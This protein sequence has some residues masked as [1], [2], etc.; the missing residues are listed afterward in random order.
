MKESL[1]TD[2]FGQAILFLVL[3]ALIIPFLR[4]VKIPIALGYLL[5]GIALG[6]YGIGTI[7]NSIPALTH[8][9]LQDTAHV[10]MLAE[11]G[12]ILLLFIIGLEITPRRLWQMR[13]LVFGLGGLQVLIT[14]TIIGTI[15]F[16]WG[17]NAQVSILL[18]LSLA[19]S[20]TAIVIQ[21]LHEQ[22]LFVSPMGRTT[23]SILLL[24]DLAVIPILF[25]LT[26]FTADSGE[27]IGAFLSISLAKM[28]VTVLAMYFLGKKILKPIFIF[29]NRHGGAE[30]FMALS[31]LVIITTASIAHLAGLSMA[32]GAFIAGLLLSDTEYRHEIS[33]LIV[34]FKSM[35]LG[36][37]FI[38]FG[39][40]INLQF[41]AEKPIWLIISVIGLMSIKGVITYIL[42]R[43]WK[44]SNAISLESAILLSQA[45]EF[46]L[47]VTGSALTVGFMEQD[48]GQ[49]MLLTIGIT[50]IA[51]P[52]IAPLARKI[53]AHMETKNSENNENLKASNEEKKQHVVIF[54]FGHVGQTVA[55]I[56]THEGLEIHGFDNNIDHV[57]QAR[58][59]FVPVYY[60]DASRKS[61]IEAAQLDQALCAVITTDNPQT[62]S[63]IVRLIRA[64]YS[65]V[66]LIVRSYDQDITDKLNEYEYV[67]VIP[68]HIL[69]SLKLT[70]KILQSTGY[71][72]EETLRALQS[73]HEHMTPKT[74]ASP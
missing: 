30:V 29:A 12:I 18:G 43:L 38:S 3:S 19:L 60:G 45:G 68:E 72:E 46:G 56:L 59:K 8:I 21:W 51:T 33:S 10:K 5:T 22:K 20:S 35:L 42:C 37:F 1:L 62:T 4:S 14:A 25:L 71:Q 66:P 47:L 70:E 49:F 27:N 73:L 6:P 9:T 13:D 48:V 17:N 15:A 40:G 64:R 67:Y 31:L 24:Q 36:I 74:S 11:F 58:T 65:K 26:I 50:M 61:T 55:D 34:P 28:I 54:G 63:K 39:M 57:K 16:T 7:S 2:V 69:I 23:F 41:L 32:L 44:Q 52:V 53:G